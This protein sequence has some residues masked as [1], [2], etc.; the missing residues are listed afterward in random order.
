[1]AYQKPRYTGKTVEDKLKDLIMPKDS[2]WVLREG[3]LE[4]PH[5]SSIPPWCDGVQGFSSDRGIWHPWHY[6]GGGKVIWRRLIHPTRKPS[7]VEEL[8]D[9]DREQRLIGLSA[10]MEAEIQAGEEE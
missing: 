2:F 3:N 8:A 1:M 10:A 5:D 9:L 6:E 7:P 4:G